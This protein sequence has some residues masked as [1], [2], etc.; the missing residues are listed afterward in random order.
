[1]GCIFDSS[2]VSLHQNPAEKLQLLP[3]IRRLNIWCNS[4]TIRNHPHALLTNNLH[5]N[6]HSNLLSLQADR[7][8]KCPRS[9][10]RY[11]LLQMCCCMNTGRAKKIQKITLPELVLYRHQKMQ[12]SVHYPTNSLKIRNTF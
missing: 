4:Q 9:H 7:L 2:S 1:M 12:L 6:L 5:S 8:H 11:P 3:Y 10:P